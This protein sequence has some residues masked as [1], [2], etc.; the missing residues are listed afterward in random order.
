MRKFI[1]I[2][3]ALGIL[4]LAGYLIFH[5][6]KK[7]VPVVTETETKT[8][9]ASTEDTA[10]QEWL[11][12]T[13]DR[14]NNRLIATGL[15]SSTPEKALESKLNLAKHDALSLLAYSYQAG[16]IKAEETD[17]GKYVTS[18]GKYLNEAGQALWYQLKGNLAGTTNEIGTA[19]GSEVNSGVDNGKYVISSAG[20]ITGDKTALVT[21]YPNGK[22]T[23]TLTRC[24][25]PVYHKKPPIKEGK[26]DEDLTPKDPKQDP[27]PIKGVTVLK[28]TDKLE[29][30]P[31]EKPKYTILD[32]D[33]NKKTPAEKPG[34][35]SYYNTED[36]DG[37]VVV[38]DAEEKYEE[39][40][41]DEAVEDDNTTTTDEDPGE[42]ISDPDK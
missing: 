18:D 4:G 21:K 15:D 26:T 13:V 7:P 2:V 16:L 9:S 29:S 40:D 17:T 42:E 34:D 32:T 39:Y 10:N 41:P 19:D 35:A 24:G 22:V 25:N 14:G 20:G 28:Q 11:Q 27:K 38:D 1:A 3:V 30:T 5:N 33:N 8:P 37:N 36:K 12:W 23:I 6:T 31:P